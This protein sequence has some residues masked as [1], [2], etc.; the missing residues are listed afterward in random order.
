MGSFY[1]WKASVAKIEYTSSKTCVLI[2]KYISRQKVSLKSYM[3]SGNSIV[4]DLRKLNLYN[5]KRLLFSKK[6]KPIV[7]LKFMKPQNSLILG[8]EV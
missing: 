2:Q 1:W 7:Q 8:R 4:L 3:E 5:L 6:L